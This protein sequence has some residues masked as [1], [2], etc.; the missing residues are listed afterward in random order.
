MLGC[1]FDLFFSRAAVETLL[2]GNEEH[3]S[4]I[5]KRYGKFD[6]IIG[7]DLLYEPLNYPNLLK[8][9]L[10][11]S[12]SETVTFLAHPLRHLGEKQFLCEASKVFNVSN[13]KLEHKNIH[14]FEFRPK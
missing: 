11:L 12:D 8:T 13:L 9:I 1:R 2:W 7:S 14:I 5:K 3:I 4:H 6:L 10:C